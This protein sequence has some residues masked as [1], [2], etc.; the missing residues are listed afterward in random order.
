MSMNHS[1]NPDIIH[2]CISDIPISHTVDVAV[3]MDGCSFEHLAP[4][5]RTI[6]ILSNKERIHAVRSDL[7]VKHPTIVEI[8]A[9][10]RWL[11][12]GPPRTRTTGLLVTGAVGAGKTTLAHIVRRKYTKT[13]ANEAPIILISLTGARHMRTV[14]GRVLEALNGPVHASHRTSDREMAVMRILKTV[15]CRAL[16]VDEVQDVLAGSLIE[17]RRTL[18]GI[19]FLMNE[20]QL[21]ILALGIPAAGEA[22]RSDLHLDAR[23]KR[24]ELP[25]WSVSDALASFLFNVERLLPLRHPSQLRTQSA[26][27]FLVRHANGSLDGIMTLIRSAA[28]HAILSGEER[29]DDR[30]LRMGLD[31]PNVEDVSHV[32]D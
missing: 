13:A 12:D 4:H 31:T 1:G 30:M 27:N 18:D 23:F 11:L 29:I 16:I 6:A 2:G 28:V 10:T 15:R 22:F 20:L 9:Y 7:V 21:P 14:Y 24:F 26:M 25:Q 17:Q 8:L 5:V 32:S 3:P 19:K